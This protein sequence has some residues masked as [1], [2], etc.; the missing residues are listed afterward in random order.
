MHSLDELH[1]RREAEANELAAHPGPLNWNQ[2]G[3]WANGPQRS[4]S[5]FFRTEKIDG[6]WWLVDPDGRLFW[7]HGIDCVRA[8]DAIPI[9][10]RA[11]WPKSSKAQEDL[12]AFSVKTAETYFLIV[13][14]AMKS[15]APNQ[16]PDWLR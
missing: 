3:G 9:E 14:D 11:T 2:Y 6:Q 8:F 4:A 12:A 7:S 16:L 15:V 5:G 10:E 13:R 1:Q